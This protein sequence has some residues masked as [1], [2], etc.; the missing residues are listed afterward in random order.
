MDP[1]RRDEYVATYKKRW[2]EMA[3]NG[4]RSGRIYKSIEDPGR[5][6]IVLEWDS[7]EAHRQH[8][9]GRNPVMTRFMEEVVEPNRSGTADIDHYTVEVL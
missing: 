6:I 5:V 8:T 4:W 7:V 1:E 2:R 9:R 3:L